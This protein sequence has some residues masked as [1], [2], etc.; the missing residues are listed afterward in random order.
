MK[1]IERGKRGRASYVFLKRIKIAAV[2]G[3]SKLPDCRYYF[4]KDCANA[5][6]H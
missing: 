2:M 6:F 1:P 4:I 3:D 5:P